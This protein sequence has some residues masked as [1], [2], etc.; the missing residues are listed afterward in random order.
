MSI[1]HGDAIGMP[2]QVTPG[3]PPAPWLQRVDHPRT[4]V[5]FL[6]EA[7]WGPHHATGLEIARGHVDAGDEVHVVGCAT[8]LPSCAVNPR[9]QRFRCTL[10]HSALRR[11]LETLSLTDDRIHMLGE[12]PTDSLIPVPGSISEL[13]QVET[14]GLPLGRGVASSL[15]SILRESEPDLRQHRDLVLALMRSAQLTTAET[16]RLLA[17]IRPD[18]VYVFNGRY[19]ESFPVVLLC[20]QQGVPH[21]AHDLGYE[22]DT[23][24]IAPGG[25]IHNLAYT[26]HVMQSLWE[27]SEHSDREQ[28]GR[29][30]F[31]GRRYGGT[32]DAV[33]RY[34]WAKHQE[35]GILP[36]AITDPALRRRIGIFVSSEDELTALDDFRNPVYEHQLDA[37]RAIVDHEWDASTHLFVRSHPNLRG[38]DNTQTRLIRWAGSRDHTTVIPPESDV[39][40]YSL[41]EACDVVVSFGSTVGIEAAHWGTPSVLV[42]RAVWEDLGVLRPSSHTEVIRLLKDPGP[43]RANALP[44]GYMQRSWGIPFANYVPWPKEVDSPDRIRAVASKPRW[45]Q[46][47]IQRL[48]EPTPRN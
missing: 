36:P 47:Q 43:S 34:R 22:P 3:L 35:R 37:F 42:G 20:Q 2:H 30:F 41:A 26:K 14:A 31:D 18:L 28:V 1:E 7:I 39:D 15:V 6:M 21:W 46:A 10:C 4:V 27:G 25:T 29:S 16:E 5:V 8:T 48:L 24:R 11:G 23:Y 38:L 45:L 19:A 13:R 9:H 17:Q 44:Y 33:Q 32:G 12:A 40:T